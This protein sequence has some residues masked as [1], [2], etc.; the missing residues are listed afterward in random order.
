MR[1]DD[2]LDDIRPEDSSPLYAVPK[3]R[4]PSTDTKARSEG[5]YPRPRRNERCVD[6]DGL[7]GMTQAESTGT[8]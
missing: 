3:K 5:R 8:L 4:S 2:H 6:V 7:H 1:G